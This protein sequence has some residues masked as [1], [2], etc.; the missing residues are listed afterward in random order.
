M[1][2]ID[3]PEALR[4]LRSKRPLVHHIT[5][6]VTVNDCANVTICIGAAPVMAEARE[7]VQDM[8]PLAGALVLNIGT[9]RTEQVESMLLAGREANQL[10]IP[11]VLDPVGAG[12]TPYRTN[13]ARMLLDELEIAVVK[14][15]AGE[16]GVLSG[17]GGK[18]VGV[19]SQ[20]IKGEAA[21]VARE[22]AQSRGGVVVISGATDVISDGRRTYLVDNGHP[23][24]GRVSGTGCMA[25]SVLAS[26]CAVEDD[27]VAAS[28]AA[29][30][31]FG[32]AGEEAA[33][34]CDGPA[35]YKVALLD[36]VAALDP[37]DLLSRSRVRRL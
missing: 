33:Q 29:L 30:A 7:E 1:P 10:G 25:T 21:D 6:Y 37:D 31:C 8:V 24:M 23:M 22:Y 2:D 34:R 5:N 27:M 18:V 13:T 32:L 26:F 12:A 3:I 19:D 20:G 17:A 35:S 14:G 28:V 11:I 15:N 4:A 16:I 9:L 36:A